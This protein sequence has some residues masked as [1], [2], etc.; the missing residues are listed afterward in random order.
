MA[1]GLTR[2]EL[3]NRNKSSI[4]KYVGCLQTELCMIYEAGLLR[5]DPE[6]KEELDLE[7]QS[8]LKSNA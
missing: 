8:A 4:I 7:D 3:E 5:S 2:E 6:V 1:V